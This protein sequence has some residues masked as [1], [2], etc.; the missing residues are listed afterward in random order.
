MVITIDG[1]AGS[2]KST[3]A[4]LLADRLG[5][6]YLDT[7]A[8]YRAVALAVLRAGVRPTEEE[9]APLLQ[10]LRLVVR[11]EA[12]G[13]HVLLDGEDVTPAI[14]T[15]EVGALASE[16]SRLAPVRQKLV[17]VQREAARRALQAGGGV[18]LEG[19]DTGTVVFPGADL[20]VFMVAEPQERAR[21]RREELR[22]RGEERTL[23]EVLAEIEQRD[24][25][26]RER[27]LAPLRKAPDAF[28]LDTTGLTI[29]EQV[30]LILA[31]VRERQRRAAV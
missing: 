28:E 3:T 31:E 6:L 13:M 18:V 15:S 29:E 14:R 20:K 25:Q 24:R 10:R 1:P 22:R 30:D 27:A 12:D 4:R 26:D 2:G 17:A 16:I 23:D 19:R 11:H 9:V 5:Y 21:R 8:M 7:G